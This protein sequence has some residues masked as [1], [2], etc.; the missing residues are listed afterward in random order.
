MKESEKEWIKKWMVGVWEKM[1]GQSE[2]KNVYL[3]NDKNKQLKILINNK[4][5]HYFKL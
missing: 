5:Q 3:K 1:K 4:E 2:R